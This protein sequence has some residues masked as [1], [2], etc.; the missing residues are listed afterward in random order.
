MLL[1][2]A[3]TTSKVDTAH[4]FVV[5]D[6]G[7][8]TTTPG[9]PDEPSE[10]PEHDDTDSEGVPRIA[11]DDN[12]QFGQIPLGMTS[13]TDL[14]CTNEGTAD[15]RFYSLSLDGDAAFTL[16]A[17][18]GVLA[19]PG[20]HQSVEVS[21]TPT[22]PGEVTADLTLLTNDPET[23][24]FEVELVGV[25]QGDGL[26][27]DPADH[28]FGTVLI[29]CSMS[30]ELVLTNAGSH[31]LE[32]SEVGFSVTSPDIHVDLTGAGDLPW[33][34]APSD[35]VSLLALYAPTDTYADI[36]ELRLTGDDTLGAV[37]SGEGHAYATSEESWTADGETH[38][39]ALAEEAVADTVEVAVE[40]VRT[41]DFSY[42]G[43][44]NTVTLTDVPAAGET[45]E[46]AYT[47]KG[48]C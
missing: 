29:G 17:M 24:R 14:A 26:V 23:P 39:F 41:E 19:A 21:F 45:I 36:A 25:G 12:V 15:L 7:P 11:C 43:S 34:L 33:T 2:L 22:S 5:D 3:C 37:L 10:E 44:S 31:T 4:D 48:A 13:S 32:V 46:I 47:V 28:D 42:D 8:P 18:T 1:W 35:S 40:G 27:I 6:T 16:G 38:A 20:D 30:H 9:G